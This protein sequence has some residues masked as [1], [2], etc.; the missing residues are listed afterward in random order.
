MPKLEQG[1]ILP[2][3]EEDRK[4][5]EAIA[6]DPDTR[7]LEGENMQLMPFSK[8]KAMRKQGRPVKPAPKVQVSIRYSPEV[9]AAF[10]ATGRGWQ[11]RMDAAMA[12]WLKNHSPNDIK[13]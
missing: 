3:D 7:S 12:D 4:I 2:T 9:I 8:L 13:I 5:Q 6:Q 1:T 11:T 10:K